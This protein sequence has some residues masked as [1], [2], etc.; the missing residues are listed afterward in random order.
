TFALSDT[1]RYLSIVDQLR[2]LEHVIVVLYRAYMR[3]CC[4][5]PINHP[6][7][8]WKK[9]AVQYAV[10]FAQEHT[11]IFPGCLKTLRTTPD[12]I[13]HNNGLCNREI[14][15][16]VAQI[17]PPYKLDVLYSGN[18]LQVRSHIRTVDFGHVEENIRLDPAVFD[19]QLLQRFRLAKV[20]L[21]EY[22]MSSSQNL[23][24]IAF[25][26]SQSLKYPHIDSVYGEEHSERLH[27][28]CGWPGLPA[29]DRIKLCAPRHQLALD[30]VLL[31][32]CPSLSAI[33][34]KDDETFE[35]F[36]RDIH[37]R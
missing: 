5:I 23:D 7:R 3:D 10:Q 25:A 36:Y 13:T 15:I 18:W 33:K 30:P 17:L 28:G 11:R 16:A 19:G 8:S 1:L 32:Q 27:I 26:F 2:R 12:C 22:D 37:R 24:A 20:V 14:N 31:A 6:V 21:Q 4:P 35:Y 34:I 29:L 9:E